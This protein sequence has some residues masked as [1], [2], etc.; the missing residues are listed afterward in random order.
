VAKPD[1]EEK[2]VGGDLGF[3]TL[4]STC[5]Q[6]YLLTLAAQPPLGGLLL[7]PTC[8]AADPPP[9]SGG[10]IVVGRRRVGLPCHSNA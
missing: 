2:K 5:V 6:T 7:E 1:G 8:A 3:L 4:S 9:M 10:P